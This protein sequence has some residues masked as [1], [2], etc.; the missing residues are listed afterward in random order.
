MIRSYPLFSEA[1]AL[2][3]KERLYSLRDHNGLKVGANHIFGISVDS[4]PERKNGIKNHN[5]FMRSNF[6]DLLEQLKTFFKTHTGEEAYFSDEISYPGFQIFEVTPQAERPVFF[7]LD[8]INPLVKNLYPHFR[9][10]ENARQQ[11]FTIL[12]EAPY[13]LKS[14]L[15]F[16]ENQKLGL[17]VAK[18]NQYSH[19]K[20]MQFSSLHPYRPGEINIYEQFVHSVYGQNVTD[21]K[22]DR[23]TLQGHIT[24][25]DSGCLIFW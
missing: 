8:D 5:E 10:K 23:V 12:L 17:K 22:L 2:G 3:F 15:L 20:F 1:E 7:H 25:T 13:G 19:P 6:P 18:S 21:Q 4:I 11:T 9:V 14:G 24:Q 16:Y